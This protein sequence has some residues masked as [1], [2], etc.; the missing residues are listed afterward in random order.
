MERSQEQW[1]E[2]LSK[3]VG[4]RFQLTSLIQKR[5]R[6][7]HLGGRAFMPD[8]RNLDELF[9]L[10]L[11]QIEDGQIEIEEASAESLNPGPLSQL[12]E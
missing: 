10:V 4:G 6:E 5:M 1:I 11:G 2:E 8:V 3:K 9:E 7:Y 12:E